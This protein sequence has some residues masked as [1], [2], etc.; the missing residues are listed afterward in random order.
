MD[1]IAMIEK[2]REELL[3]EVNQRCDDLIRRYQEEQGIS[4]KIEVRERTLAWSSPATLKGKYPVALTFASGEVVLTPTWKKV[5]QTIL[6]NYGKEG[7][8]IIIDNCQDILF[9]GF[10]PNSESAEVLSK[11]LGNK[12]VL[13][14][15]ISRGKNDPSQSLQMIQRPLMTPDELKSL[16]KGH[17]ILAKTGCHPMRTELRL[18]F[19]WGIEFEE[20]YVA[21]QHAARVVS[22][23]DRL[24]LEQE[25]MRRQMDDDMEAF[26]EPPEPPG[27]PVSGGMSHGQGTGNVPQH[28]KTCSVRSGQS[29]ISEKGIPVP[30]E[31][32]LYVQPLYPSLKM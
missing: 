1:Y 2:V 25:I 4:P 21:E 12:T 26:E 5:V 6:K 22:Y 27:L 10:A 9:G 20:E 18:F 7:S 19:K 24:T 23:A 8:E 30:G 32:Q 14:G 17:F 13:S 29:R 15:S 31:R 11:A 16:P 28:H 3:Q